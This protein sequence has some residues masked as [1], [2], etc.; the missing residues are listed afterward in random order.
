MA[1]RF[2]WYENPVPPG[3]EDEK[4]LHA[5]ITLNGK[6][7]TARIGREI[8]ERC[9]LTETDVKAVLDAL[10]HILGRELGDGRQVHLDGIG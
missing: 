2:E 6:T 8:Q 7:E 5:R 10:S 1:I 9:L 3:K 4:K